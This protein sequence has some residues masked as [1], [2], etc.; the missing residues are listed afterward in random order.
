MS[1]RFAGTEQCG[2]ASVL[3]HALAA[4]GFCAPGWSSMQSSRVEKEPMGDR[5]YL[6]WTT[7]FPLARPF[8]T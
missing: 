5:A 6:T 3:E 4:C 1:G 2:V 7:T 8:S